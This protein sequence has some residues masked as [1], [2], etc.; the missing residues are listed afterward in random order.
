V[1]KEFPESTELGLGLFVGVV[2]MRARL[3][4]HVVFPRTFRFPFH[5]G[6]EIDRHV[7]S[8]D[9]F[10]HG[11]LTV[12][13]YKTMFGFPVFRT[14]VYPQNDERDVAQPVIDEVWQLVIFPIK[15]QLENVVASEKWFHM[16]SG[17]I[18]RHVTPPQVDSACYLVFDTVFRHLGDPFGSEIRSEMPMHLFFH[19]TK[20]PSILR[21]GARDLHLYQVD[22]F[23]VDCADV[24]WYRIRA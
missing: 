14:V 13:T 8:A 18:T 4:D 19:I 3:V 7:S 17:V 9:E 23:L 22:V 2:R 10:C 12:G 11:D 6:V 16:P 21:E 24:P 15:A 20:S 1:V 5:N